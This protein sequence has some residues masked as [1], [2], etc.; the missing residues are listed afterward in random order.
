M[1]L[2]LAFT[3]V[4]AEVFVEAAVQESVGFGLA[5]VLADFLSVLFGRL[6][7]AAMLQGLVG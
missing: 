3:F 7:L 2:S 4:F 6:V 1:E 5:L